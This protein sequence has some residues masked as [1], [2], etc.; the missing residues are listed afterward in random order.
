MI[1]K[2]ENTRDVANLGRNIELFLSKNKISKEKF[3]ELIDVSVRMVYYYQN[4]EKFPK[5]GKLKKIASIFGVSMD[6]LLLM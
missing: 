5:L 3:A 2:N 6:D 4:G 1:N